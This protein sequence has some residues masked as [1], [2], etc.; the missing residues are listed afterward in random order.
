M[1]CPPA[2]VAIGQLIALDAQRQEE[3]RKQWPRCGNRLQ[4]VNGAHGCGP[5]RPVHGGWV[6]RGRLR[7]PRRRVAV[8]TGRPT[9]CHNPRR[10]RGV[11]TTVGASPALGRA[12][13]LGCRRPDCTFIWMPG[14]AEPG[15][16]MFGQRAVPSQSCWLQMR[17]NDRS[18]RSGG[19]FSRLRSCRRRLPGP[20]VANAKPALGH[21]VSASGC[22]AVTVSRDGEFWYLTWEKI[23]DR[24]SDRPAIDRGPFQLMR[25]KRQGVGRRAG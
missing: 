14:R 9:C 7:S 12:K 5:P 22:H 2:G 24:V 15:G 17:W 3:L 11:T 13:R 18:I 10:V 23:H 20:P 8:Y 6:L 19:R 1:S 25:S 21:G 16:Q 4:P